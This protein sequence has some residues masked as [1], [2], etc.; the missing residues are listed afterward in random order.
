MIG[1]AC[2]IA[3][4]AL[5]VIQ[6]ILFTVGEAV[7]FTVTGNLTVVLII[8]GLVEIGLGLASVSAGLNARQR[9]RY[10]W[11]LVG[12]ILGMVAFGLVIGGFLGLVAVILI[13]LSYDEFES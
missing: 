5:A 4:G 12:S 9:R 10:R 7:F 1:G 11:S 3:A 2:A 6:G 8:V 13:A